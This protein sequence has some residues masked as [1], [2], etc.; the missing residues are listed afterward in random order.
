MTFEIIVFPGLFFTMATLAAKLIERR[1]DV[2]YG[3]YIRG[4]KDPLVAGLSA[5]LAHAWLGF[6]R[7]LARS[8][9]KLATVSCFASAIVG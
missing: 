4:R 2:L 6:R 8:T 7:S 5:F 3:P 9:L 1:R